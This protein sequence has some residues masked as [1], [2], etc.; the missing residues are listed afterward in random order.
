MSPETTVAMTK[1]P[2][3]NLDIF[4]EVPAPSLV[5]VKEEE[6]REIEPIMVPPVPRLVPVKKEEV[7]WDPKPLQL[8]VPV[9]KEEE[10]EQ[11]PE[12]SPTSPNYTPYSPSYRRYGEEEEE[13]R[14]SSE[15]SSSWYE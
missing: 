11:Y 5:K 6:I 12:Y 9:K 13:E 7:R 10:E 2:S 15:D 14:K 4:E 1:P 8:L 3:S